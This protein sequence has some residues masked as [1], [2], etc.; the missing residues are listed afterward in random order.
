MMAATEIPDLLR[1]DR[2]EVRCTESSQD[3]R[4]EDPALRVWMAEY[5]AGSSE[6]FGRLYAA[7]APD[8]RRYFRSLARDSARVD[9]L[10]QE[11]FLQLHRARVTHLRGY[12]VRPWVFA[13]AR[14]VWL[15]FRRT[16]ARRARHEAELPHGLPERPAQPG[17]VERLHARS[18]IERALRSAPPHGRRAFL[19]HHLRGFTFDE[20][21]AQLGIRKGAAKIRSSRAARIMRKLLLERRDV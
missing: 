6:A 12:P 11:T 19:L 1:L 8:L 13:I 2:D 4:P 5:Q 18:E 14:R 7:V 3:D 10:L 9:D 15:M 17:G 20:I 16:S 21:A